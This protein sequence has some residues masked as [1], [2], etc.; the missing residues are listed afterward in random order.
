MN[1]PGHITGGIA[2]A[3]GVT[4][5][6]FTQLNDP[7]LALKC[8]VITIIGS[9]YPDMDIRSIPRKILTPIGLIM[10]LF[11]F[12][13]GNIPFGIMLA[14]ITIVPLLCA[15]RKFNHSLVWMFMVAGMFN[16]MLPG[17]FGAFCIGMLTHL[18]LDMHYRII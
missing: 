9:L 11:Y 16:F 13:T 17:V 15:H 3:I 2:S 5:Y 8:G 7:I 18:F 4:L 6:S 1:F 12:I 10:S 14:G